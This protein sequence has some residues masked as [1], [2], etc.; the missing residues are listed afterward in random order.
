[1]NHLI[2]RPSCS[3]RVYRD[4]PRQGK[5]HTV[6]RH[7]KL[8]L[9]TKEIKTGFARVQDLGVFCLSYLSTQQA[10]SS[11]T[12]TQ[13]AN[14]CVLTF[15][16]RRGFLSSGLYKLTCTYLVNQ[17]CCW[18][19]PASASP[20]AAR[21]TAFHLGAHQ[22]TYG[23]CFNQAS[24]NISAPFPVRLS[25]SYNSQ[26][27]NTDLLHPDVPLGSKVG[28]SIDYYSCHAAISYPDKRLLKDHQVSAPRPGLL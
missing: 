19:R 22:T 9:D 18:H 12:R 6:C 21:C 14:I 26:S 23:R 17:L 20:A 4:P 10:R 2:Y 7:V 5:L 11:A 15:I 13:L 28:E 1:M 24:P 27:N 8:R 3:S 25:W 16:C